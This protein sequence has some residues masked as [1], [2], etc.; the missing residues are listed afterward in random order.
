MTRAEKLRARLCE[1]V[2]ER[3][4]LEKIEK[5][6]T[7]TDAEPCAFWDAVRK[8]TRRVKSD[9]SLARWQ[10]LSERYFELLTETPAADDTAENC[11]SDASAIRADKCE[12]QPHN[13]PKVCY[14]I[15][16]YTTPGSAQRA[17]ITKGGKIFLDIPAAELDA[18][19]AEIT[20]KD[21]ARVSFDYISGEQSTAATPHNTPSGRHIGRLIYTN[22][23][24][25]IIEYKEPPRRKWRPL[26]DTEYT[27][28]EAAEECARL[29][30]SGSPYTFRAR[31]AST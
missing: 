17:E 27:E 19:R 26:C 18:I 11:A 13:A 9:H 12:E 6:L 29:N 4:D 10:I 20:R 7:I 24:A 14:N 25:Y 2:T 30:Q 22:A 31:V 8:L 28:A 5:L 3:R 15:R 21:P 16:I 1:Y 23:P